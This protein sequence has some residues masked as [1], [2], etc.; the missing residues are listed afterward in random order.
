[1]PRSPAKKKEKKRKIDLE[2]ATERSLNALT[3]AAHNASSIALASLG[4]CG[5][6]YRGMSGSSESVA[7][8]DF[9]RGSSRQQG[10]CVEGRGTYGHYLISDDG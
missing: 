4:R 2:F 7:E 1:M 3:A 10:F 6:M 5:M 9:R 8:G